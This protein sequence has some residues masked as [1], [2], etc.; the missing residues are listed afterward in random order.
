MSVQIAVQWLSVLL[1]ISEVKLDYMVIQ[2]LIF[3][4]TIILLFIATALFLFSQTVHKSS[5]FS[6]TQYLLLSITSLW[7]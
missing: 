3:K 1:G 5:N 7:F 4:E 2:Y 6:T